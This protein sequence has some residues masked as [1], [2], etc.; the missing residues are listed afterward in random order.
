MR[1]P[2]ALA[3][4]LLVAAS[5][6]KKEVDYSQATPPKTSTTTSDPRNAAPENSTAMN[7]I[8]PPQASLPESRPAAAPNPESQVDLL[9]YSIHMQPSYP[10][11][12]QTFTVVNAGKEI[13]GLVV[14]GN[15]TQVKLANELARGDR[16]SLTIN[17][18][19]GTYTAWCPVDGHKGKGMSA[20]FTVR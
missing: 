2:A 15:G 17:L 11:G 10:A 8:T 9:E 5:A 7:P 13:H 19:P 3:L 18:Q 12:Q 6:C 20:T 16:G 1:L 14:E 4:S